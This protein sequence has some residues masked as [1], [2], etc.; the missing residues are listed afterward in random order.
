MTGVRASHLLLF[1]LVVGAFCGRVD[2][3]ARY[4]GHLEPALEISSSLYRLFEIRTLI[5]GLRFRDPNTFESQ[6]SLRARERSNRQPFLLCSEISSAFSVPL[7]RVQAVYPNRSGSAPDWSTESMAAKFDQGLRI[8]TRALDGFDP[9]G[10]HQEVGFDLQ[11]GDER[12]AA[13]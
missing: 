2:A 3:L 8:N 7:N 12:H 6:L 13:G 10:V 5:R 1:P 9:T 11:A 4:E